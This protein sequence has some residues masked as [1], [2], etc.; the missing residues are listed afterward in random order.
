MCNFVNYNSQMTVWPFQI[1]NQANSSHYMHVGVHGLEWGCMNKDTICHSA[2]QLLCPSPQYSKS[3]LPPTPPLLNMQSNLFCWHTQ[4]KTNKNKN[5]SFL[6][7]FWLDMFSR[8]PKREQEFCRAIS[9]SLLEPFY[10]TT[11]DL[12]KSGWKWWSMY[13]Y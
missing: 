5:T 11:H 9:I 2:R 8:Q 12:V 10:M 1:P 3:P 4:I 7:P 6:K 13:R